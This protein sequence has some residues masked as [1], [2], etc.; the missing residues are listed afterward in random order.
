MTIAY[1]N[2]PVDLTSETINNSIQQIRS[3]IDKCATESVVGWCLY[4]HI[5]GTTK[6]RDISSPAK[7]HYFLLGL[8]LESD[9]PDQ[10]Q[11]FDVD[12]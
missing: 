6:S 7:Q 4:R 9:E 10:P 8:L 1:D 3:V 12:D 11:D 5:H 2:Q